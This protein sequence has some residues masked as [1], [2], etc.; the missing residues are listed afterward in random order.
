MTG[1]TFYKFFWGTRI[2]KVQLF[3]SKEFKAAYEHV[4]DMIEI[5]NVLT[6]DIDRVIDISDEKIKQHK[7]SS[8]AI[9]LNEQETWIRLSIRLLI[10]SIESTCYKL[11]QIAL[12]GYQARGISI[13]EEDEQKLSERTKEGRPKFLPTD[14]NIKYSFKMLAS[15]FNLKSKLKF[16][17]E[18]QTFL[19]VLKKRNALTHPKNKSDLSV[20]PTDHKNA[21]DTLEW[22]TK[23]LTEQLDQR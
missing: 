20:T 8:E 10:S 12:L 15:A 5:S 16:N 22:F 6:T 13:E 1:L 11:K 21:A 23:L 7:E 3:V 4:K 2:L 9:F 14:E 18:W 19:K 17:K